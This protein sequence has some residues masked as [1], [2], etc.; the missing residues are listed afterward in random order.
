MSE[1]YKKTKNRTALTQYDQNY[2]IVPTGLDP[3]GNEVLYETIENHFLKQFLFLIQYTTKENTQSV[4]D[5]IGSAFDEVENQLFYSGYSLLKK[6]KNKPK[7]SQ[8]KR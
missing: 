1:F 4:V 7:A 5:S 2:R 6:L 8:L 3:T